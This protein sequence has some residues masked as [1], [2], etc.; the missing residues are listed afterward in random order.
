MVLEC[1]MIIYLSGEENLAR[2][3]IV[4]GDQADLM[5]TFYEIRPGKKGLP[6]KRFRKLYSHR[7]KKPKVQNGRS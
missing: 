5:L 7:K 3:E 2:P 1:K 4:F 6:N